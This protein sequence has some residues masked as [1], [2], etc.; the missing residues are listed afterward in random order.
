MPSPTAILRQEYVAPG[1]GLIHPQ[2]PR[3]VPRPDM[4]PDVTSNT[5]QV[6]SLQSH[7]NIF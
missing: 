4:V 1:S 3:K 5:P 7:V 6:F 2:L